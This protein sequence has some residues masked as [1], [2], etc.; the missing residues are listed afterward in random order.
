MLYKK[1]TVYNKL[2]ICRVSE[3]LKNIFE[4]ITKR[5]ILNQNAQ[6]RFHP[7]DQLTNKRHGSKEFEKSIQIARKPNETPR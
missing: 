4:F 2:K 3:K 6:T 1:K 5:M 7:H